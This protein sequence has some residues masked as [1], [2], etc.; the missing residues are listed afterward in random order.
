METPRGLRAVD[1]LAAARR[2]R[3]LIFGT[4]DLAAAM[5]STVEGREFLHARSDV[6][7]ASRLAGIDG[8]VDGPHGVL[9]DEQGLRGS[10][11]AARALGFRGKV[12]IHPDQIEPVRQ[13]FA[14]SR[15]DL[16][17]ARAVV[18][19]FDRARAAGEAVARLPDGAFVERPVVARAAA[20]LGIDSA[21][22]AGGCRP[23]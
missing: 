7:L 2:V 3:S 15:V 23:V 16:A 8:P 5:G 20:L 4:L 10:A 12:V 11:I 14:P 22:I 17:W 18:D 6:V 19:A 9:A 13:E 1:A 21:S